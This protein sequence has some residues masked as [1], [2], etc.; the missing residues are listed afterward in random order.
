MCAASSKN[1][2][3]RVM[4]LSRQMSSTASLKSSTL[5]TAYA[6]PRLGVNLIS[7]FMAA[8]GRNSRFPGAFS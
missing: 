3:K 4:A 6:A 1:I 8:P 5:G 7:P 2:A